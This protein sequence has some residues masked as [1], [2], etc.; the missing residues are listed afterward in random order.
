MTIVFLALLILTLIALQ[1]YV[2]RRFWDRGLNIDIK[3]SAK[4]A[5]EG[6]RLYLTEEL[7]NNKLLPLPWLYLSFRMSNNL[8]FTDSLV[9]SEAEAIG[10]TN[11]NKPTIN[12][13]YNEPSQNQNELFSVMMFQSINRRLSLV[14]KKRGVYRF[15]RASL[16]ASNL[17]HTKQ[18]TK[19][20]KAVNQL[21]VFP[22]LIDTPEFDVI[23]KRMDASILSNQLINPDP[24]EF[25]GIREYQPTDPA[26]TVN[27]KA[28]A[29]AQ[30]LMVNIHAP[31]S[32]KRLNIILNLEPYS[33]YP[34]HE[35]YEEAL[36]MA[37]TIARHYVNENVSVAFTTNGRDIDT[38][39]EISLRVGSSTAHLY[40][41]FETLARIDLILDVTPMA[42]HINN[43][44]DYETVYL[45]IS[46]NH[47]DDLLES[48]KRLQSRGGTG[49]LIIPVFTGTILDYK[50][51]GHISVWEVDS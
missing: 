9:S 38:R 48:F 23:Y 12:T 45:I 31:I 25:R 39:E 37:A 7:T 14:C 3:F 10:G 42:K 34:D 28:T 47:Q 29:I 30:Q 27:F 20:V 16:A 41:I 33:A 36:R 43:I 1:N 40:N 22:K 5:F 17:L 4:E 2:Y 13:P 21:V 50:D 46:P 11:Q 8:E 51:T 35:L 15:E 19:D 26:H 24:F 44:T 49:F 32:S 6:D 18:F